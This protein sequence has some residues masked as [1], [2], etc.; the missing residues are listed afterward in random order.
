MHE[1]PQ[2]KDESL[3]SSSETVHDLVSAN[4]MPDRYRLLPRER[5]GEE[6]LASIERQADS[7]GYTAIILGDMEHSGDGTVSSVGLVR[8][9]GDQWGEIEELS[10][11]AGFTINDIGKPREIA[12]LSPTPM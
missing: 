3:G 11:V 8:K 4:A 10:A 7:M 9:T 6:D 1:Q 2:G 12:F 5:W